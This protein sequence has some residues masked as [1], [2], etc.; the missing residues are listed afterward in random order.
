MYGYFG[1]AE[2]ARRSCCVMRAGG[3]LLWAQ[4]LRLLALL[5][6]KYKC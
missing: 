5:V 1:R 2:R 3:S 6:H 4:V